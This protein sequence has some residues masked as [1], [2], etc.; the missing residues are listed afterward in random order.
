MRMEVTIRKISIKIDKHKKFVETSII[1][2]K[3]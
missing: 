1:Y 2:S 3:Q